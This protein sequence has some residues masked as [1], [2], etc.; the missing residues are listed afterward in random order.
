VIYVRYCVVMEIVATFPKNVLPPSSAGSPE[1]FYTNARCRNLEDHG[2]KRT[3]FCKFVS[4][5]L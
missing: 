2:L 3:F 1:T 5:A 4:L